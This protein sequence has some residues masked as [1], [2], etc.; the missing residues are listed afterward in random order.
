MEFCP[1]RCRKEIGPAVIK[2]I[3]ERIVNEIEM[4]IEIEISKYY[5][6][7][8]STKRKQLKEKRLKFR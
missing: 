3:S 4:Q 6:T 5:A 8:G 1:L 2:I 7:T